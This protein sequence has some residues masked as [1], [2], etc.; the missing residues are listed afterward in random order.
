MPPPIDVAPEAAIVE[1]ALRILLDQPSRTLALGHQDYARALTGIIMGSQP[2][3]AIGVFGTWGTGKT[4]LMRA[5]KDALPR[6]H[7]VSVEFN[8]WRYEK[9]PHLVVPLLDVVREALEE[10]AHGQ[11]SF[12][13][14]AAEAAKA[15]DRATR[16]LVAGF[17]I[18]APGLS[19]SARDAIERYDALR[20]EANGARAPRSAPMR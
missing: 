7:V 18:G 14:S 3:F 16:A 9:E 19:F 11:S 15:V 20:S 1:P 17:E 6:D 12:A 2:Q 4:T 5:V 10:R 13:R 8:A